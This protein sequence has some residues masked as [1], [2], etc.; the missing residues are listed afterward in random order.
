LQTYLDACFI[1]RHPFKQGLLLSEIHPH[2]LAPTHSHI[3]SETCRGLRNSTTVRA[4]FAS[5]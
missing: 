1:T 4:Y 3:Y 5:Q 2:I